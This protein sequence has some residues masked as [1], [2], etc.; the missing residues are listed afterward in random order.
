MDKFAPIICVALVCAAS[1]VASAGEPQSS[2]RVRAA[3]ATAQTA[4]ACLTI[5]PFYW[6]V[7]DSRQTLASGSVGEDAPTRNTSMAIASAS[8]WIYAGYVAEKRAGNLTAEDVKFLTFRSGYTRFVFCRASQTVASCADSRLNGSGEADPGTAGRFSYSGGHMQRHAIL[9]GLGPLDSSALGVEIRRGLTP[10]GADWT[11]NYA[12]PQPAGG[13]M[14]TAGDYARFL[15]AVMDGRLQ[16]GKLLGAQ[17]VCTNSRTCP[18]D[19][20]RTPSPAAESWHYSIGHWVEDDPSVGDGAFSSPGAF[21]FYPWI[22]SDKRFYGIVARKGQRG[23]P[24]FSGSDRSE[25][26][27]VQSVMCGRLIRAA[28]L[29]GAAR[30]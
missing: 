16:I 13:G 7:G 17:P 26:P 2:Q 12:Q 24:S 18:G 22:T 10:L 15:R 6:E 29:D 27:G 23:M 8:K 20:L 9:L 30:S 3:E 14:T 28:W 1:D 4:S 25:R 5:K 11:F 19:A 21:G